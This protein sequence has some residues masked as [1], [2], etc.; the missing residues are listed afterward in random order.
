MRKKDLKKM[1]KSA[2][3][4][5]KTRLFV[6]QCTGDRVKLWVQKNRKK[7]TLGLP[8]IV[9]NNETMSNERSLVRTAI[10]MRNQMEYAETG[11][12][13][14]NADKELLVSAVLE[15]WINH[16]IVGINK[17]R[18]KIAKDKFLE[19]NGDMPVGMIDRMAIVKTMDIMNNQNYRTNYV[20]GIVKCIRAFYKWTE[21]RGYTNVINIR[22]L[23]PPKVLGKSKA[24]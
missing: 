15:D 22:N 21:H 20:R 8:S 12:E 6:R 9:I 18:A 14:S 16:Y 10:E 4:L 19:A 2:N 5:H 11:I 3:L 23:L 13:L 7:N 1:I 24:L 17:R